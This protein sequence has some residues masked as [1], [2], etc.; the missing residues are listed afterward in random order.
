M[1]KLR[2]VPLLATEEMFSAWYLAEKEGASVTI[3]FHDMLAAAPPPPQE[4]E[5]ALELAKEIMEHAGMSNG[6]AITC[7]RALLASWGRE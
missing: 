6:D 5:E 3:C 7:A 1:T 4:I 2:C